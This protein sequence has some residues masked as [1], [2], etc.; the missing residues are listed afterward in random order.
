MQTAPR[1]STVILLVMFGFLFNGCTKQAGEIILAD[2]GPEK[3]TVA[4]YE[5]QLSKNSGGWEAARSL[6]MAEKEKFLDLLLNFRLK[7]LDARQRGLDRDPEVVKEMQEYRTSLA[8]SF[9]L[10]KVIVTPGLQ[11]L[12]ERR[13]EEVRASNILFG[14]PRTPTPKDTLAAWQKA[15]EVLKRAEA[16][17]DF[18]GLVR[19]FSEDYSSRQ[20][21]GDTY[22]FSSGFMAPPLEDA[23]F[24]LQPGQVYPAPVRSQFGYHVIK[25]TDRK[26]NRGQI[27]ASHIMIRFGA[28]TPEDSLRAYS[29]I[30]ALQD[31]LR[32]GIDFGELAKHHS[33]DGGSAS[34]GGDL[35]FFERRRAIQPFDEAAFSLRVGEVS[36]IVRTPYGY[37]LIRVTDEKHLAPFEEMKSALREQ[38]QNSRYTYNYE[39]YLQAY[40]KSVGF[41]FYEDTV[42]TLLSRSDTAKTSADSLWDRDIPGQVREKPVFSFATESVS[43]DSVIQV[44][45]K[46]PEFSNTQLKPDGIRKALERIAE[47]SLMRYRTRDI[48]L[49]YPDFKQTLKEY[50]EG[51]LLYKSEQRHVWDR[52]STNDSLLRDYYQ[53]H[54]ERYTTADSVNFGEIYISK[55]STRA[56]RLID[57]LKAGVD[58]GALASRHTER[59]DYR[60]TKG[61]WRFH[62]AGENDITQKA[63]A[64]EVGEVS[65]VIPYQAGYSIIKVIGKEKS[66]F[67]TFEEALPELAG[68]Y[69][70]ETANRLEEEWLDALRKEYKVSVWKEKLSDTFAGSPQGK[71]E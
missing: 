71:M 41:K 54:R 31:S 61:E 65:G 25:L 24:Q 18:A 13:K 10:D 69:H 48:E 11:L 5:H 28:L 9:F 20:N 16:G 55:D 32:A 8:T 37:H 14:L 21:G 7:L 40:K 70:D 58:F 60:N 19:R 45:R 15:S 52:I 22:Y 36:G 47:R 23:C 26:P 27:R 63:W 4:E 62:P 33:Q 38:Y 64:M 30:K 34:V 59:P 29:A 35:G 1:I 50:E 53:K 51:V 17:E 12:Y 43:L 2:I 57:S 49:E 67:K 3:L 42:D 6:P 66:R 56:L 44:L 68:H 39:N 46:D